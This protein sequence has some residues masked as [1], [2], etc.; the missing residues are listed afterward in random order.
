MTLPANVFL[1]N[2]VSASLSGCGAS[3]S[4]SAV[5]GGT[6]VTLTNATIAPNSTCTI[7]VNVTSDTQGSYLNT[8]PANALQTQ[9]GLTN[10]SPRFGSPE[11]SADWH[12][13]S[14]FA[15]DV[16]VW[17]HQ[18][19]DDHIAEPNQF[20]LY[21]CECNRYPAW[22]CLDC[23]PWLSSHYMWWCSFHHA[24]AYGQPDGWHHPS[25]ECNNSR[26]VYDHIPGYCSSGHA[27]CNLC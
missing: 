11:C 13:K 14:I 26:D 20:P 24:A 21:R 22:H 4:L 8:I 10:T 9:Q 6:T 19:P 27:F 23:C 1:A 5:S 18:H 16:S 2:P 25:R 3:A 15:S 17:R 12:C 7:R